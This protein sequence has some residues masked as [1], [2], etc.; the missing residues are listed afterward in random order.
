MSQKSPSSS[1]PPTCLWI[2]K[3]MPPRIIFWGWGGEVGC[4]ANRI[5]THLHK[6]LTVNSW[7]GILGVLQA[8]FSHFNWPYCSATEL[9]RR[10]RQ[11][12]I[13]CVLDILRYL[14]VHTLLT[15]NSFLICHKSKLQ[16]S[17]SIFTYL[18][19][20]RDTLEY[21]FEKRLKTNNNNANRNVMH[22]YTEDFYKAFL[23][24]Y[25]MPVSHPPS[26][27]PKH[28]IPSLGVHT[29]YWWDGRSRP[30]SMQPNA[31]QQECGNFRD[32][33][34]VSMTTVLKT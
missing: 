17:S 29:L 30:T 11:S 1:S 9:P 33:I 32:E 6:N 10:Q 20:H 21:S 12:G 18:L 34:T 14:S 19:V 16:F 7:T 8:C 24:R 4:R 26:Q 2:P 3:Q 31:Q 13:N 15:W 23:R 5:L 27:C 22:Y 25:F 28:I